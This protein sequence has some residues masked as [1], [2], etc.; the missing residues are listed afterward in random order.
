MIEKIT[1]SQLPHWAR[2]NHPIMR[3]ILG[4]IERSSRLRGLL[5]IF[6]GLALIALVVGLGY[7]TAKQDSGNDE[8]ALR[9]ILYGPLVG[10]QT[11]ALVLALAMTSNVIAVERQ[12]QTWDSLKLTTVGAS[13]S[14]RARWIAVFFRLKWLLLVILI[15][16]LVYIGLLMRDIVDFQGR[17]LDLYISGITPEISLNV[18][19]LLM[20]ALMTAFVMLPFIA[21]GL[22]A[23]VGI[24][25]AVYTRARSVVILGLLT[26]VGMRILLSIFA[27]SLDDKLFEGALD[28][29][30]YE[31]WGR[32]LF[33][34]LEGDMALKL[35]HL[36]TLGQVWA[37]VD[38]TVYVGGVLLGIVLIEA[39][40]A[41]GMVLFAAWRATKPTRN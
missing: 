2:P 34:A 12:K 21:V 20:T 38:Y 19:I 17:A 13:L 31:A 37:D 40:L 14:L 30:R 18:A 28:M 33:S 9:D 27:L 15:G 4:P 32:L 6:I 26:L 11:V 3:S 1:Y 35:L 39:A 5:R 24:L 25:L 10:A 29:G 7:V 16:R 8:P 23:A 41:N 36:E 22:A